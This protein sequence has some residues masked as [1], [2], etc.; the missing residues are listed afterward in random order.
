MKQRFLK[1]FFK[2]VRETCSRITQVACQTL[3]ASPCSLCLKAGKYRG[4]EY[5]TVLRFIM[6]L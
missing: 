3:I 1:Y 6:Q 4:S 2:A 5:L